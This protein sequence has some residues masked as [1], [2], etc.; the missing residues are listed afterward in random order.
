M[1]ARLLVCVSGGDNA[2]DDAAAEESSQRTRL[3][4]A[5]SVL[6]PTRITTIPSS[7]ICRR[8]CSHCVTLSNVAR[9]DISN[10]SSAP[11]APRK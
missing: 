9:R 2:S 3:A 1:T 4:P 6:L 5:R 8:S 7:A 10:T 11:D